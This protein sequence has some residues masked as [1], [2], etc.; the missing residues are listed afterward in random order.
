M[1]LVF[2]TTALSRF[3]DEDK[4]LL[5]V[6]ANKDFDR[7][8]V[9]L[10]TDAEIRFGFMNGSRQADNNARYSN[11]IQELSFELIYPNQDTSLVYAEL[12]TWARQHGVILSNNDIWIAATTRQI[13]GRLL[14]L[15][16]D[17]KHLPQIAL[18]DLE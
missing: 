1:T 12:A 7:Y 16:G 18:V 14:T 13:G 8:V 15:D 10:A 4:S 5:R 2:D 6:V 3:L 17:F 11:I 9:P